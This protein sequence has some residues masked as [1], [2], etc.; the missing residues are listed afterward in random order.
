MDTDA[1]RSSSGPWM[2]KSFR[3]ATAIATYLFLLAISCQDWKQL[4]DLVRNGAKTGA[5]VV[6]KEAENH[7][8]LQ[9][10]F[11]IGSNEYFGQ[12]VAGRGGLPEFP[13]VKVGDK[14][15]V[16]YLIGHP[17]SSIGGDPGQLFLEW[18][19]LLFVVFPVFSF[20][21]WYLVFNREVHFWRARKAGRQDGSSSESNL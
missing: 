21:V 3:L 5:L 19:I 7:Q 14:I 15:P 10:K 17:E 11:T 18:S 6:N 2:S 1:N 9:Y 13:D 4:S 8:V 16:T 20:S 12:S